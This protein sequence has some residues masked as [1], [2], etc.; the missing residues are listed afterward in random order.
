[1][2]GFH[3]RSLVRLNLRTA[4][5]SGSANNSNQLLLWQQQSDRVGVDRAALR[6]APAGGDPSMSDSPIF[7]LVC[8]TVQNEARLSR[9]E[10][11]GTVRLLLKTVGLDAEVLTKDAA[12][13]AVAG[14]LEQALRVR[15]VAEPERVTAQVLQQLRTSKL[16]APQYDDAEAIFARINLRL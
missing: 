2:G 16:E 14:L 5:P 4:A 9:L 12:I 6:D 3:K 13:R 8:E 7:E 1:V 11:R 10:A 15:R